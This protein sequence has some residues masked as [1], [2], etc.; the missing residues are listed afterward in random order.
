MLF[1]VLKIRKAHVILLLM[2]SLTLDPS[3]EERGEKSG[4]MLPSLRERGWG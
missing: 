2:Q 1:F 4:R 3:P